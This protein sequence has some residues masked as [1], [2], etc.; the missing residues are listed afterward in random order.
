MLIAFPTIS[1]N[2]IQSIYDQTVAKLGWLYIICCIVSFAFLGWLTVSPYGKLR[3]GG[4]QARPAYK[5]FEWA[6]M[7]FTSGVGSSAV[8]LGFIEPIY[9]VKEPPFGM[10]AFSCEAYEYAHMYGQFHWGLSAWAFYIPAIVCI[11][12]VVYQKGESSLRISSITAYTK[13]K[14]KKC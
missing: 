3:L 9:Y 8:L 2:V 5:T 14:Q 7:I 12:L 4:E 1:K 6:G 10:E 13:R 11:V